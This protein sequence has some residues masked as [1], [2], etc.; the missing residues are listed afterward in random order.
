MSG[1]RFLRECTL[2]FWVLLFGAALG[3]L[4]WKVESEG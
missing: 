3:Y 4:I 2:G 1:Q